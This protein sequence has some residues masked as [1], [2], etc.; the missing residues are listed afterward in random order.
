M[1]ESR[2]NSKAAT[3]AD[4]FQ[5]AAAAAEAQ[6][7]GRWWLAMTPRERSLTIYAQLRRL[8]EERAAALSS[9][10]GPR[11]RFRVAREPTR[12]SV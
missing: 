1:A 2:P 5:R 6:A 4:D 3:A 9:V 12:R 7:G 10:P 11:S 8:D